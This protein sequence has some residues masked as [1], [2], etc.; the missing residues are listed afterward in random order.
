MDIGV[1]LLNF[2]FI[3]NFIAL[4]FREILW[5]RVLL[6]CGYLFRFITQYIYAENLNAS[7]W[8]IIFVIINLFQIIQII[9][10]RRKRF[11]EPKIFDIY[12]SVF[13][14]LTSYEFLTFWKLGKIKNIDKDTKI[15]TEGDKLKSILLLLN[16]KVKVQKGKSHITY[17]PRGSFMGEMSFISKNEASA[18]VISEEEV[19]Y[20]E[21]TNNE[22]VKIQKNNRIF[23]TKIQ[24]ILL[25]DLITK[26]K[27]S[28][29]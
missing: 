13:N 23:W 25:N 9:N 16:G 20:I 28:N 26:V 10:E 14:S 5:I 21:W 17:L 24:N 19:S 29:N 27:R 12:E 8:M 2:G 18:D 11:I 22:L 6:T 3:L 15:I 4:A 7:I 1:I